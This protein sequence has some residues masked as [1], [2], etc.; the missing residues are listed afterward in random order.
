MNRLL[1]VLALGQDPAPTPA[2]PKTPRPPNIVFIVADDMHRDLLNFTPEGNGRNFTPSLDRLAREGV[3]LAGQ[4]IVSPICTPSRYSCLTGR[5]ACRAQNPTFRAI[6]ESS[7]TTLVAW[8]T[9]LLQDELN[10]PKLLQQAGYVTGTAGKHHC[11]EWGEELEPVSE[12]ESARDPAVAA[13]L[14]ANGER[15]EATLRRCGFDWADRVYGGNVSQGL[16]RDVAVHNLDWITEGALEFIDRSAAKPFFLWFAPTVP[17][18]P[19]EPGRS[20]DADPRA[21]AYG[22]LEHAPNVLP[23]RATLKPR[24]QAVGITERSGRRQ[25]VLLL[26]LDDA[27]GALLRR[28]EERGIADRTIVVFFN[29][30][31]QDGKGSIYESGAHCPSVVWRQGG[32]PCG[33]KLEQHISN[34]DLAPTILDLAGTAAPPGFCDGRSFL[35]QLNGSVEPLHDTLY[36]EL[37]FTR[38]VLKGQWKYVALRYPPAPE[39]L[40]D[41]RPDDRGHGTQEPDRDAPSTQVPRPLFGHLAGNPNEV[42]TKRKHAGYWDKDQLYDLATD[43][44]ENVNLAARPEHAARLAAMKELL[45]AELAKLPGGFGELKAIDVRPPIGK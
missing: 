42:R 20:W 4:H 35:P 39:T 38:G 23:P 30:N 37:G 36:F 3:V 22:F 24:L 11:I 41:L 21:T 13:K 25:P 32:F 6:L 17:H 34:I 45:I 28:L 19:L 2:P 44:E 18:A 40:L 16:P 26:W 31:G 12:E 9:H 14:R 10:L 5:Y 7:G 29:D 27:I 8:N 43:P 1:L 15:M 33:A